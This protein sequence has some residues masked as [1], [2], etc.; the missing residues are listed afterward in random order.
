MELTITGD[1]E[2][3][4]EALINLLDNAIKYSE[5]NKAIAV[6]TGISEGYY[7]VEVQDQGIG[8]SETHQQ[9]IFEKFYRV[10]QGA[11]AQRKGTGLGLSLVKHI[12]DAHKGSIEVT[13]HKNE[14]SLFRLNFPIR[15]K[16]SKLMTS[17]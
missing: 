9:A 14:G 17:E 8:I 15:Y 6:R 16:V 5:D 4:A 3:I 2:S 7:F 1:R 12:M 10:T 13:S 11:S